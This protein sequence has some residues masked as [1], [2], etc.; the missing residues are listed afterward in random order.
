MVCMPSW[1]LLASLQQV[2]AAASIAGAFSGFYL[3]ISLTDH[4]YDVP[5]R[6]DCVRCLSPRRSEISFLAIFVLDWRWSIPL[7]LETYLLKKFKG[8]GTVSFAVFAWF[9]LPR[10]PSTW[11]L[12]S[13]REKAIAR[14]R[15]LSDSSV[16][17]DER[18]DVRDA[19]RPFK[20]PMYWWILFRLI[21]YWW[22]MEDVGFGPSSVFR[23]VFHWPASTTSFLRS[24]Q[25]WDT[26]Q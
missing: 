8:A 2:L 16:T 25:A 24:S 17:V 13:A 18:L 14:I 20:D 10:S 15:V 19:F 6:L 23:L 7:S 26:R 1:L 4:F 22:L 11:K 3:L 12:L 5:T 21:I 9:W